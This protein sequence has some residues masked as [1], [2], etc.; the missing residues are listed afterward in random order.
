MQGVA[1]PH[2]GSLLSD[3]EACSEVS[4]GLRG[5][6]DFDSLHDPDQQTARLLF[7]DNRLHALQALANDL[8][9]PEAQR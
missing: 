1:D 6:L 5:L 4:A 9:P 7:A 3:S 2:S 8:R